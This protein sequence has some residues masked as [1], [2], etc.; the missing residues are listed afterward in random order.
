MCAEFAVENID[1]QKE[2]F[3]RLGVLAD[4]AHPYLTLTH[5]HDAADVAVFKRFFDTG[6]LYK[7]KKPIYWCMHCHTALSEAEIEYHDIEGPSIF[8]AF[9]IKDPSH[10]SGL[11]DLAARGIKKVNF[12]IWTTTPGRFLQMR[13]LP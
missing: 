13:R 3:R 4:W 6:A 9:Q 10:I 5:D 11:G 2:G 1:L 12:A 8:V 7:G